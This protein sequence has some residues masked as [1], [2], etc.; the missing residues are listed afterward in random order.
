METQP[1]LPTI[2]GLNLFPRS[3]VIHNG[4]EFSLASV[5]D[6]TCLAIL[7]PFRNTP[8]RNFEGERNEIGQHTLFTGPLSS[9]N[10]A[11]MRAHL[12]WLNP[13]LMGLNTSAGLGDRLGLAT[14][15]HVRAVKHF[16]GHITP[17]FAQQSIREMNRTGRTPRQVM[18][19][20]TWGV[21][22]E[23]WKSPM[24]ADADH[25]KTPA[26]IDLCLEAG[27][28]FF[29]I[30]PGDHVDNTA[31]SLT[32]GELEELSAALPA[33]L[34]PS[35]MGLSGR[36]LLIED[37]MLKVS[38]TELLRAAVKY[39]RALVHVA[40]MYRHLSDAAGSRPF[41]LE[42]S[43]DETEQ[44]T[45]LVEHVYI[46]MGLKKMGV[47]WVSLA[48]RYIGRF[49]KGVDYLGD[50]T[51]F[52]R[53]LAGHAAI[54]R[55]FGPYKLS[56]HSGSDKFSIYAAAARQTRGLVHLKT[57][58]TSYLEALR[59]L[60]AVDERL[61]REIYLFA[62]ERYEQDRKTYHVSAELAKA[63]SPEDLTRGSDLCSL[64][65]LLEQF[66]AREILHVTFGSVLT[67]AN[68][69]GSR[70]FYNRLIS[71]LRKNSEAYAS[72]LESHFIRHLEP[73]SHVSTH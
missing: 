54:A 43:V 39:G 65:D 1:I 73:F 21:F 33:E 59:T 38:E 12:P 2:P 31:E 61:F 8:F 7:T 17:V 5:D 42:V 46:A 28:T 25:L 4:S 52:E 51:E 10:A 20:A 15:G 30:D 67:A 63:P 70:R 11:A 18:D 9:K 49:E 26:D 48:P 47:R 62:Y 44:P 68:S 37:L 71:V 69:D 34:Q 72:N 6:T 35:K 23:G 27:F 32:V 3:F 66:D 29:T 56:L 41:E 50:P 19:D 40:A 53:S 14:P 60:A 57:A 22:L 55:Q 36:T 58:G 24:G 16:E 13:S 64:T 45:S